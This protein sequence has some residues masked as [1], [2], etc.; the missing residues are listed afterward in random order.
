MMMPGT[1]LHVEKVTSVA[2]EEE[3]PFT[4]TERTQSYFADIVISP[5]MVSDHMSWY[6]RDALDSIVEEGLKV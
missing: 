6:L 1:I 2:G 3:V 4:V 5:H